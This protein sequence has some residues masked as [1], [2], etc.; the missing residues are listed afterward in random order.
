MSEPLGRNAQC[1]VNGVST[2]VKPKGID[3]LSTNAE[4]FS[5]DTRRRLKARSKIKKGSARMKIL[6]RGGPQSRNHQAPQSRRL[7]EASSGPQGRGK[8]LSCL[9]KAALGAAQA[10]PQAAFHPHCLI[11]LFFD[12]AAFALASCK[13]RFAALTSTIMS[14][15]P[16][17]GSGSSAAAAFLA[18]F[19]KALA[20]AL[21]HAVSNT[22]HDVKFSF[23]NGFV[24]GSE[25]C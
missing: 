15:S 21:C 13:Y 17:K 20:A 6:K 1:G 23:S 5:Q 16:L 11:L 24:S 3:L 22:W 2:R 12:P 4:P 19:C 10:A 8:A 7:N 14:F 9:A 25:T 18:C